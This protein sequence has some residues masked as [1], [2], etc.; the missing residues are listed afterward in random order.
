MLPVRLDIQKFQFD[1][2]F[3]TPLAICRCTRYISKSVEELIFI[4][5]FFSIGDYKMSN[6]CGI[7]AESLW[8]CPK[9]RFRLLAIQVL[10]QHKKTG[11]LN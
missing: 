3:S 8:N 9:V 10:N 2:L 7:R 4:P 11:Y 5:I 6:W 1:K